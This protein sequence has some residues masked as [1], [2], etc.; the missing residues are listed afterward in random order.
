MG[1]G[2]TRE[3]RMAIIRSDQPA[4]GDI[5]GAAQRD[6]TRI[7]ASPSGKTP[8]WHKPARALMR[9]FAVIILCAIA[10][11]AMLHY[12]G[13]ENAGAAGAQVTFPSIANSQSRQLTLMPIASPT[14]LATKFEPARQSPIV[15]ELFTSQGCSSCPSANVVLAKLGQRADVLPLSFAVQYW[16][17]LGWRD[18]FGRP[19]YTQRQRNYVAH[20]GLRSLYTPQ[21]V[22]DGVEETVGSRAGSLEQLIALRQ[23]R[24]KLVPG[25]SDYKIGFGKSGK[26]DWARID[27][28]AGSSIGDVWLVGFKPGL[29]EVKVKAGENSG[30]AVPHFNVVESLKRGAI[31][32]GGNTGGAN[33]G[34]GQNTSPSHVVFVALDQ[35]GPHCAVLVQKPGA[36]EVLAS[37]VYTNPGLRS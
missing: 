17:Y 34:G 36:G 32:D 12:V 13:A 37:A 9:A 33:L 3:R 16:D 5:R 7:N 14:L 10:F 35:C 11:W 1:P 31:E 18:T 20:M 2:R 29:Q 23:T 24:H 6:A 21:A 4:S 15:V 8:G 27:V 30:R 22:V 28:P 19:E 25:A 26:S